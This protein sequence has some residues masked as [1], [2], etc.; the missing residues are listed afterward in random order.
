[1]EQPNESKVEC[2]VSFSKDRKPGEFSQEFHGVLHLVEQQV[3][4]MAFWYGVLEVGCNAADLQAVYDDPESTRVCLTLKGRG[5]AMARLAPSGMVQGRPN[6]WC[7][8]I[9]GVT[10]LQSN[11]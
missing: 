8:G 10:G 2:Q 3:G 6:I 9:V 5:R 1:M 7:L 11:D 4:R